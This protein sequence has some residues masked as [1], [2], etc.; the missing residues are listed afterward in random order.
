MRFRIPKVSAI[1]ALFVRGQRPKDL[2]ITYVVFLLDTLL[3]Y[4]LGALLL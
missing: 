1:L 4:F 3:I 2:V